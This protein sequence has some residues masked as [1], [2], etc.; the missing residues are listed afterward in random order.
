ML[1][2]NRLYHYTTLGALK[3][4]LPG[5]SAL[6]QK[7]IV[8]KDTEFRFTQWNY[9]ND[10]EEGSIFIDFLR[11][12]KKE[13]A[14]KLESDF[15]MRDALQKLDH[16]IEL[17]EDRKGQIENRYSEC[18][19]FCGSFLRDSSQFWLSPYAKSFNDDGTELDKEKR[20]ICL[21]FDPYYIDR[22]FDE[23]RGYPNILEEKI[24]QSAIVYIDPYSPKIDNCVDENFFEKI[25]SEIEGGYNFT[26]RFAFKY[27]GWKS[28]QEFRWMLWPRKD[29]IQCD[30]YKPNTPR[31]RLYMCG[32][33]DEII[34]GPGFG[35]EDIEYVQKDLMSRGYGMLVTLSKVKLQ[36]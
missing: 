26:S 32:V 10:K 18:F 15:C 16:Y 19:I 2:A 14:R 13:I 25:K 23:Y 20:G 28:E 34:L 30:S 1:C 27:A 22:D 31:A 4:I 17:C 3:F 7:G 9:L 8:D 5:R 21:S 29:R 24:D 36:H 11:C 33:I 35:E 6:R 12:R